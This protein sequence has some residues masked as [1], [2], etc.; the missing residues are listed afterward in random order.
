MN[1]LSTGVDALR[2]SGRISISKRSMSEKAVVDA[3][4]SL[5]IIQN[6]QN[7]TSMFVREIWNELMPNWR[8]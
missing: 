4:L 7:M 3:D 8:P 5:L 6:R 1:K 2:S